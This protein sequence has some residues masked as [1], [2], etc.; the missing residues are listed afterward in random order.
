MAVA[1]VYAALNPGF[2]M[3]VLFWLMVVPEAVTR[4]TQQTPKLSGKKLRK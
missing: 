3:Y 4:K 2:C 1:A